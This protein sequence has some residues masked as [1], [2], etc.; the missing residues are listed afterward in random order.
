MTRVEEAIL[1]T[2]IYADIFNFPLTRAELHHYLIAENPISREQ[3]EQALASSPFLQQELD[4]EPDYI[5]C[6]GRQDL[7][8]L[9]IQR[10]QAS[11]KLWP[12]ARDYGR[13][14]GRLP[15]V[16]MV[17]MTGALA[18]RNAA[19]DDDDLDYVLVTAPGRVWLARAF[20]IVLV[21]LA[22][23]RGVVVC[24]NYLL[25][26]SALAQDKH[27]LFVA[28]EVTQMVP[29]HGD[30]IYNLMRAQNDWVSSFLPNANNPYYSEGDSSAQKSWLK[31]AGE[32][33]LGGRIGDALEHWEYRRKLRRFAGD[34][35]TPH[36]AAK[37][38]DQHVKGHFKDHGHPVM[39]RYDE[40]L[41]AY[42]LEALPLAGD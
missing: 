36:S 42:D 9:R 31:Q 41:R 17:A 28:H 22:K 4:I 24:P 6:A 34:M 10:D 35:L 2:V 33:L 23:R 8:D 12:L 21:R 7:I 26:E 38:D 37:L 39:Q 20:A 27:D 5:I 19:A 30:A 11:R 32:F 13:A 16:R 14:L 15:F 29:I 1:R 25:A 40:R 18:M 3:V